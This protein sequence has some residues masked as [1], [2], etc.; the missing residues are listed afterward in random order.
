MEA[1]K[2]LTAE[3]RR[4]MTREHLLA[5]AAEVFARR[6][7]HAAT[8][9]EVAQTAGFTTGAIYSNF[10]S[11]EDLFL[12][13]AAEGERQLIEAFAAAAEPGLSPAELI[14]SLRSVYS[15]ASAQD[16]ER[17]WQLWTEFTLHLMRDPDA[18]RQLIDQQN[19]GLALVAD[20]VR[21]QCDE[22]GIDPPLP[23]E[24]TARIFLALFT[25]LWQQ[26][27][28][29]GAGVDDNAF[30]TAVVFVTQALQALGTP[31]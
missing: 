5:A 15:G 28:V 29:D 20:L 2:P 3:R 12:A 18:R 25:G 24:L 9:E 30:P 21:R 22:S 4:A 16:R 19:V 31:K 1:V 27:A 23:V 6:G 17:T 8:L 7:Y 11:K 10:A 26:Q 14:S 13:L